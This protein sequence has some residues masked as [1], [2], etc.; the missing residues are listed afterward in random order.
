MHTG[1][2][3]LAFY[4]LIKK[5]LE[6]DDKDDDEGSVDDLARGLETSLQQWGRA[7]NYLTKL[8]RETVV[9]AMD[10]KFKFLLKENEALPSGMEGREHL[11]T[12]KFT[13]HMLKVAR[14]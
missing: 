12:N 2:P 14:D 13:N 4:S 5:I 11:F 9:D 3:I 1:Q 10:P 6:S 7:F 8:C